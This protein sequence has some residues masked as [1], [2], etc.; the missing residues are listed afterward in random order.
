T[1]LS[2]NRAGG[3]LAIEHLLALGH[4]RLGYLAGRVREGHREG[5][6]SV[7][8]E[9]LAGVRDAMA[10]A[11]TAGGQKADVIVVTGDPHGPGGEAAMAT[12]MERAPATTGVLAFNDLMAL[13]AL[14]VARGGGWRVPDDLSIVGFD[15]LELGAYADP[16]LTTVAQDVRSMGLL[17]VEC[18]VTNPAIEPGTTLLPVRLIR[19]GSTAAAPVDGRARAEPGTPRPFPPA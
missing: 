19:R 16:P 11:A 5:R 1:V 10:S 7:S 17:A 2:D 13:G 15:G 14:R 4:R 6:D 9:R 3:R 12:L 8:A 18:L